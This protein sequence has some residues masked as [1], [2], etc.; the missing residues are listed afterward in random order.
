[1]YSKMYISLLI[2]T[3]T[4][5]YYMRCI[6]INFCLIIML[7]MLLLFFVSILYSLINVKYC[8]CVV[9]TAGK[10]FLKLILKHIEFIWNIN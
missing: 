8:I 1:M 4:L 3:I 9:K 10:I 5:K 6:I 7:T 2:F